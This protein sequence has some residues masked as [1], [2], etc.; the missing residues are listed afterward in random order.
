MLANQSARDNR[1]SVASAALSALGWTV[2]VAAGSVL[3]RF[4]GAGWNVG[5]FGVAFLPGLALA[6]VVSVLGARRK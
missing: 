1:P 2:L 3:L 5:T 4:P 6:T